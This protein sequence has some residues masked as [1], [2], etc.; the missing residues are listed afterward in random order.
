MTY[1]GMQIM[2]EG[3]ALAAFGFL[4]QTTGEPLLKQLLRYVMSDELQSVGLATFNAWALDG[5]N[6]VFWRDLPISSLGP[7]VGVLAGV[8]LILGLTA[9][10]L[11]RRWEQD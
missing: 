8:T 5:F 10:L 11:A 2:V 3:L 4:H 9:R 1:L 7:Q 6:K